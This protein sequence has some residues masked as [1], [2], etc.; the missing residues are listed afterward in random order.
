MS[1]GSVFSVLRDRK[2][3]SLRQRKA[4][5]ARLTGQGE[6]NRCASWLI[7]SASSILHKIRRNSEFR[8]PGD[9]RSERADQAKT[10]MKKCPKPPEI[11]SAGREVALIRE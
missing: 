7:R 2:L 10:M 4:D 6:I 8:A 1:P 3:P 5:C 11:A 9:R